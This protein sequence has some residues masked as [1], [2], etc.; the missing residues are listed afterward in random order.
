[1]RGFERLS[2]TLVPVGLH[3]TIIVKRNWAEKEQASSAI[4]IQPGRGSKG[5]K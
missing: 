3:Q 2:L 5:G 4:T 1:M